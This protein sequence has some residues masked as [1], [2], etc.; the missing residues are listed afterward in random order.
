MDGTGMY[1]ADVSTRLRNLWRE[2]QRCG[3]YGLLCDVTARSPL[4]RGLWHLWLC[5]RNG[6][7]GG[8]GG[9]NKSISVCSSQ[10][11]KVPVV[12]T[13]CCDG[14]Q[15]QCHL[16]LYSDCVRSPYLQ[17]CDRLARK[18][19][20]HDQSRKAILATLAFILVSLMSRTFYIVESLLDFVHSG[21]TDPSI[22]DTPWGCESLHLV[23]RIGAC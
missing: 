17:P 12:K 7:G 10:V 13:T 22:S 14:I 20:E 21:P 5:L 23:L 8:G 15:E 1:S 4:P 2:K 19:Q 9:A 18:D 11:R 6:G 16:R 3:V